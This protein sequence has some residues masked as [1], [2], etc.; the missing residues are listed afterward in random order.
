[1]PNI[2]DANG[3]QVKTFDELLA[4]K[5]AAYQAIY[6]NDINLDSNTPDGQKMLIEIQAIMDEQ[7]LLVQINNQRSPKNAIGRSLDDLVA[8]N[9]V[10]RSGGTFSTTNITLQTDRALNLPGLDGA[11]NDPNGV[12]YTIQDNA[13]TQWI[14]EVSQTISVAGIYVFLFRSKNP[15]QILTVPNTITVP[16]SVVLG[17]LSVNNPTVLATLGEDEE[18]DAALRIRREQSTALSSQGFTDGLRAELLNQVGV[19]FADVNE[20]DSGS[21][22]PDGTPGHSIWV[23]V[24]GG[25]PI[26]IAQSI[27]AK[28]NSGCGMRGM[29]SYNVLQDDGTLFTVRW[30]VVVPEDLFIQLTLQSLDGF[31]PLDYTFIKN[32]LVLKFTPG[33]NQQVNINEIS[34][35]V[36]EI[37]SNAL[38]VPTAGD[39]FSLTAGSYQNILSPSGKNKQ[40]AVS[41]ARITLLP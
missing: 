23:I 17:V 39:G 26:D 28:R 22:D 18:T 33:I 34:T 24:Q 32:Q 15:G 27:Y 29:V 12:G 31:T 16:V 35:I 25:A 10:Q 7:D 36:Q 30:D 1:M 2:I 5:T 13:G 38:V 21:T 41:A 20:N 8:L 3:L 14:L 4:E 6:G 37:D 19:T 40:F 9:G 11:V